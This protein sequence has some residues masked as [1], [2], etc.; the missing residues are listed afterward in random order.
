M[1]AAAA[2]RSA[3]M[4][5]GSPPYLEDFEDLWFALK[6]YRPIAFG[7]R[8]ARITGHPKDAM[9]L[10]QLV[11]WTRRGRD[12]GSNGGWVHKTREH[13]FAETGLSR[14]EQENARRRLRDRNLVMEW[15]GGRPACLHYRLDVRAMSTAVRTS[16]RMVGPL[17]ASIEAIRTDEGAMQ[18]LLGPTVAFRR[19]FVDLVG[20]VNAALLLSRMVQLQRREAD[21]QATWFTQSGL[22]WQRS[23]GL[24]RVQQENARRRLVRQGLIRELTRPNT[25]KRVFT[26]INATELRHQLE[27]LVSRIDVRDRLATRKALIARGAR[28]GSAT[29]G[30]EAFVAVTRGNSGSPV[31]PAMFAGVVTPGNSPGGTV[32]IPDVGPVVA[33]QNPPTRSLQPGQE[34]GMQ[35]PSE[36]LVR[37]RWRQTYGS[38]ARAYTRITY[39][40]T[41]TTGFALGTRYVCPVVVG[42]KRYTD[43]AADDA[44]G[45]G[46]VWPAMLHAVEYPLVA[47]H[48]ERVPF[49]DRQVLLDEMASCHRHR[50]V[51]SPVAYIA[52]LV[53][54][55]LAGDFVPARA[56]LERAARERAHAVEGAVTASFDH[57][58]SGSEP[59]RPH[60]ST[61]ETARLHLA[62]I[63]AGLKQARFT[64]AGAGHA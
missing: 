30:T 49:R 42:T 25:G 3:A 35:L 28:E 27:R 23:L 44:S 20:N 26:Q 31:C 51:Q 43:V 29:P 58:G 59:G 41:T 11:Y 17:P 61:P 46:L 39:S 37:Y 38:N 57:D 14:E 12:V 1:A 60:A 5:Q 9:L 53:R 19:V 8:L 32:H 64:Q 48:L 47:A 24:N 62:A 22:E 52:G 56:H 7:T 21:Q 40:T 16:C 45:D 15:R 33:F 4:M 6:P 54:R 50:P 36:S 13:W 63:R 34:A 55:C 10:S 2:G 18:E